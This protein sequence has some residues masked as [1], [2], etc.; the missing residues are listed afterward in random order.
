MLL[1]AAVPSNN[2]GCVRDPCRNGASCITDESEDSRYRCQCKANTWGARCKQSKK[3]RFVAPV[4][5]DNALP[6]RHSLFNT[7]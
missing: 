1:L 2:P 3:A 7:W 5:V 4:H 6:R